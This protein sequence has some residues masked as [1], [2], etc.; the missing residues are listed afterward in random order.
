MTGS[1]TD[2]EATEIVK[3]LIVTAVVDTGLQNSEA[4]N[5]PD[6]A[7]AA[8]ANIQRAKDRAASA[9][10][11]EVDA[12]VET[13]AGSDEALDGSADGS[14]QGDGDGDFNNDNDSVVSL[15]T[16]LSYRIYRSVLLTSPHIYAQEIFNTNDITYLNNSSIP[17]SVFRHFDIIAFMKFDSI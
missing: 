11:S 12:E 2:Q 17:S 14:T 9:T 10:E 15:V 4:V 5:I 13:D 16:S 1:E 8:E 6:T 7:E 3:T